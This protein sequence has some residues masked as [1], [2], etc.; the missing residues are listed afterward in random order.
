M[1]GP[2]TIQSGGDQ[3]GWSMQIQP[4]LLLPIDDAVEA[5]LWRQ[6]PPEVIIALN[7]EIRREGYDP[8]TYVHAF[9]RGSTS[10]AGHEIVIDHESEGDA[11]ADVARMQELVDRLGLEEAVRANPDV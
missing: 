4:D 6:L 1:A 5:D 2:E 7:T 8:K 3:D 9:L 11:V 10:Q